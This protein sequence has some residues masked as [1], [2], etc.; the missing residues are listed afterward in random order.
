M[1]NVQPNQ[2]NEPFVLIRPSGNG[3]E[4]EQPLE[5]ERRGRDD[6]A[7][8]VAD[9]LSAASIASRSTSRKAPATR[10]AMAKIE[11]PDK[12]ADSGDK[13]GDKKGAVN[14]DSKTAAAAKPGE[15]SQGS[16]E[17]L[18]A[19]NGPAGESKQTSIDE[20]GLAE[21]MS[22]TSGQPRVR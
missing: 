8:A 4:I 6:F 10:M 22:A 7:V 9:S 17:T 19:A 13:S 20:G 15:Q 18:I 14:A 2:R 12:S 11:D 1:V 3:K 16:W 5:V 21:R